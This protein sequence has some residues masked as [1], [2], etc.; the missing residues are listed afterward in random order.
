MAPEDHTKSTETLAGLF[1]SL[2]GS[3][4]SCLKGPSAIN[5]ELDDINGVA[6]DLLDMLYSIKGT[7]E[8]QPEDARD[9]RNPTCNQ[10][11]VLPKRL[12]RRLVVRKIQRRL[13][14]LA[15]LEL[16]KVIIVHSFQLA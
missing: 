11:G 8:I 14:G 16:E 2:A 5:I 7:H 10:L 3:F 9:S 4:R 1:G 6:N 15:D 13:V 12:T